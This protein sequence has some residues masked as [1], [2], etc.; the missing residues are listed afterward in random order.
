M[1]TPFPEH[2]ERS[3]FAC[4]KE[5]HGMQCSNS[6]LYIGATEIERAGCKSDWKMVSSMF[7]L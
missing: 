3:D 7:S 5:S 4:S 1:E 2:S 6:G